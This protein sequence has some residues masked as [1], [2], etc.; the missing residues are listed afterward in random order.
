VNVHASVVPRNDAERAQRIEKRLEVPMFIAAV[1]V[2]PVVVLEATHVSHGW[3]TAGTVLNWLIWLAFATE[4]AAMLIVSPDRA[5]WLRSHPLEAAIVVLTPPFLPA[6]L[7]ALRLFRLLRLLRVVVVVKEARRL[8]TVDGIR[9]ATVLAGVAALGGGA[10]FSSVEKGQHSVWDGVWWAVT[11]MATVGYGDLA[12]QSVIGRCV[13]MALM[14][15]GI[16][17]FA[18]LTGAVAERFLST[19]VHDVEEAEIQISANVADV[20]KEIV[21]ELRDVSKRLQE[22]EAR[23]ETLQ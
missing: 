16:G 20:R 22:L 11:T 18:L 10:I 21:R 2:I 5:R 8:F 23:V 12:P 13:A 6:S 4:L 9:L 1:L 19:Q 3:K 15:I 14:L 17:F 7:Q